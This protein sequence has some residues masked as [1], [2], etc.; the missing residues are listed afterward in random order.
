ML[1]GDC[2]NWRRAHE[3]SPVLR[4]RLSQNSVPEVKNARPSVHS[5]GRLLAIFE[6]ARDPRASWGLV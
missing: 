2:Y 5:G 4:A 1:D 3:R 6:L